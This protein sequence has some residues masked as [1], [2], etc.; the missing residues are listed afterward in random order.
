MTDDLGFGT[1]CEW[2]VKPKWNSRDKVNGDNCK[3]YAR[4]EIK[5]RRMCRLHAAKLRAGKTDV[6]GKIDRF[7]TDRWANY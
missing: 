6:P 1:K 2:Q 5:G 4:K 3:F 7:F